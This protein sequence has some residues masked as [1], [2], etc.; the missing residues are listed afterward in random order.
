MT[1]FRR[2]TVQSADGRGVMLTLDGGWRARVA[3]VAPGIGRVLML[4]PAGLRE[5]RTWSVVDGQARDAWQGADRLALFAAAPPARLVKK[6]AQ[7]TLGDE[8]S[9]TQH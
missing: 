6:D 2:A 1:P 5:P 7:L 3:L 8:L 9:L 4:P